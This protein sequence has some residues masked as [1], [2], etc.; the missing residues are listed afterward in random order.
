M[1]NKTHRIATILAPIMASAVLLGCSAPGVKVL[2]HDVPP[3]DPTPCN[4]NGQCLVPIT[5]SASCSVAVQSYFVKVDDSV[6][7]VVFEIKTRGYEFG[8][9][10]VKFYDLNGTPA[11]ADWTLQGHPTATELKYK[12][13]K[14]QRGD[15]PTD[16]KYT[17]YVKNC[18][19][20]DPFIRNSF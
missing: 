9:E 19:A 11:D 14:K 20:Y 12:Q 2:A 15:Q 10:K 5:V 7:H 8:T 13:K 16:Y 18:P 3:Y 1:D 17:I 6:Q 4:G